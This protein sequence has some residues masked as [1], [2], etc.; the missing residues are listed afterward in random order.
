MTERNSTRSQDDVLALERPGCRAG[1]D[2]DRGVAEID[3]LSPLSIR[4]ITFRNRIAMSPM[5]QYSAE[6]G[7]ANDWHLVHL[8]S[9][10]VGGVALVMVEATAVTR[11]GRISPG[12]MGLW[13]DAH[14]EPLARIARFVESQGTVPG[15]QLAHAGRKASCDVPWRGGR[16]LKTAEG[17][18]TVVAPS[19]IP[20]HDDDPLLVPLDQAAI[21]GIVA[22][23]E[24]A[25]TRALAAGFKLIEI[26]AAHGYLLHEFLSPL[27]NQ[28]GDDYGGSLEN[29][30][31]LPLRVAERLRAIVPPSLPMF[32]RISA[33]D[34]VAG[35]WDIAQSV[36]L[37]KRLKVLGID[38][39]DV[40]SGG[41]VP[42]A[43][44]PIAKGFQVPFARAIRE[45]ARI[46]T[47]TVG[48]ITEVT[49]ADRIITEG[50][51]DLVLIGRELLREPYWAL[52]AEAALGPGLAGPCNMA[53]RSS[54]ARNRSLP[55]P[56]IW[57]PQFSSMASSRS[58]AS[59]LPVGNS[60]HCAPSGPPSCTPSKMRGSGKTA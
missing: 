27:A 35:G 43:Q 2:H 9:R 33:T 51:A 16:R 24:A 31:R 13:S 55:W 30:M 60:S 22:S 25:A 7:M 56:T 21:D 3:L 6:E 45:E 20:F 58:S 32:I 50:A 29:R 48:M 28:R 23:F 52:K 10:A 46:R 40:S 49:E 36:E 15:I 39:I 53:T 38:L 54:A 26:H 42:T 57:S 37:A 59:G 44:I 17:G 5:C 4:E 41:M 11:D 18:W 47:G 14:I 1:S 8:G 12:D 34:W 19:A